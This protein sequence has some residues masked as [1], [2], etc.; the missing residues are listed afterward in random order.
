MKT[1]FGALVFIAITLSIPCQ[2]VEVQPR[3]PTPV[4]PPVISQASKPQP[5][6]KSDPIFTLIDMFIY[7]P[8]GLAVTL[9][10][11][12]LFV[13]L[14]PITA[15]ASIPKP[16]DAFNQAFKLLIASPGGYT[17]VRPIGDRSFPYKYRRSNP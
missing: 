16:H 6:Y 7:R 13:G 2:A 5:A 3:Q 11:T 8:A 4:S 10:G 1:T 15:L 17:F 14:S 12:G 9:A